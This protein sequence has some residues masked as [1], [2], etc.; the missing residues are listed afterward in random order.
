MSGIKG[1]E[2]G[3]VLLSRESRE[4][5]GRKLGRKIGQGGSHYPVKVKNGE[6]RIVQLVNLKASEFSTM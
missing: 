1:G 5:E 6:V 2:Y 4:V 3:L